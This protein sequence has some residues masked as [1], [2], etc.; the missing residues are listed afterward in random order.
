MRALTV[1]AVAS[2]LL[3]VLSVGAAAVVVLEPFGTDEVGAA[4]G[5]DVPGVE[6]IDLTEGLGPFTPFDSEDYYGVT[7]H[8]LVWVPATLDEDWEVHSPENSPSVNWTLQGEGDER[9]MLSCSDIRYDDE[10]YPKSLADPEAWYRAEAARAAEGDAEGDVYELVEAP[11]YTHY[12]IDGREALLLEY[13]QHWS[14]YED[15]E[16]VVV[17]VDWDMT[18]AFLYIDL[19]VEAGNESVP[20]SPARCRLLTVFEDPAYHE[21]GL[22]VLLGIRL[23]LE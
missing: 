15:S 12:L 8:E 4:E 2:A 18:H 22:D 9:A 1:T 17:D 21:A 19:P 3:A 13:E 16:G 14:S 6:Y 20:V 5:G 23:W 10:R 11:A 7:R